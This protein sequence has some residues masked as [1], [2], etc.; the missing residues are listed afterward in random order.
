MNSVLQPLLAKCLRAAGVAAMGAMLVACAT[1][2][3]T[4]EDIVGQRVQA[5]WKARAEGDF[6]KAYSFLSPA[7][8]KLYTAEQYRNQFGPGAAIRGGEAA[9]VKCAAEKCDVRV[10]ITST[11]SIP[12][13]KLDTIA[14]YLDEV[15]LLDGGQWWLY[16]DL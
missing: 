16:H 9:S 11:P 2:P 12:G 7:Y 13:L 1:T 10:K 5:Y 4:P 14:T 6:A 3:A 15:W 8:R